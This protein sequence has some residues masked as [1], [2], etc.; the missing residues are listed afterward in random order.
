[1][2]A[3]SMG[4]LAIVLGLSPVAHAWDSV[5][6]VWSEQ[7]L[8][9]PYF[10]AS[11]LP[12][13]LDDA[14]AVQ[15]IQAGLQAWTDA[16]CGSAGF[17]Y[18]GRVSD[19]RWGDADG[20]NV[21]F[22]YDTAW[23]AEAGLLS[24]PSLFLNQGRLVDA[25]LAFNAQHF[26]LVTEAADGRTRFDVQAIAT[27]EGGHALGLW[28][29]TV[30]TASLNPSL[31]GNP[32]ARSLDPDDLAGLCSLY[33]GGGSAGQDTANPGQS[34]GAPVGDACQE[35]S[36]CVDGAFCLADRTE[37]YCSRSCDTND[38]CPAGYACLEVEGEGV[39][40]VALPE[41]GCSASQRGAMG[42]L[43][44]AGLLLTGQRR[45]RALPRAASAARD[46]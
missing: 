30:P 24:V 3:L 20:R 42:G 9:V 44:V 33:N 31:N 16:G 18:Q 2:G 34:G 1:M 40:A 10:I 4:L 13:S 19:A 21:V 22:I 41:A 32:E 46:P 17:S 5:G 39:C 43:A 11:P 38:S 37:R 27:H 45:R 6:A 15:A 23:P 7:D 36:D 29:S 8:P 25:D 28:H 12:R 14:S 35:S 26:A